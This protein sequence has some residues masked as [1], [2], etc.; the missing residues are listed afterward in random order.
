M[1]AF[2]LTVDK[3]LDHAAKWSGEREIVTAQSGQAARRTCYAHLRARSNRM[4]GALAA[5]QLGLGDRVATL[6]WNTQHHLEMYYALMGSGIVCHTL[7]P[8]LTVAHLAVMINEA[9]DRALAVAS[10]LAP[11]LAELAPLCPRI[12]HVF[13]MDGEGPYDEVLRAHRA[14]VWEQEA[15]LETLGCASAWGGFDEETPAGLCYT[16]GTT[17]AP[18][19]VLYTHRSNYLHT[20]RALQADAIALSGSDVV[21]VAVP[22]FHANAWGLPFAAPAVGA[23]LVLPGRRTDGASL[24]AIMRDEAVSVAVGI[25]TLWLGVLDHLDAVDGELP[26][27]KRVL[28]GGANCPDALIRRMES[29]LGARVQTS[30]GMTELSPVGTIA[31]RDAPATETR[32]SGRPVMGLDLKL[33]DAHGVVLPRQRGVVGHLKV[34]GAS[35]I[36]RYFKAEASAL[37]AE[38]YFDTGDLASID[39]AGNVSI[40]GRSK[41]LIKSGGEWIN[42]TEIEDIVGTH[43][44]VALAAVIARLDEKWGERPVLI[45]ECRQGHSLDARELL[46]FLR[47]KVAGWWLPDQILEVAAMPLASTGKIDKNQLRADYANGKLRAE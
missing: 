39:D 6:G 1:Q 37:D 34:K 3:F 25:Q 7:N 8:R 23:K 18:K 10:S 45:V 22:M 32:A 2:A 20:L 41:D 12:E 9:E 5:L 28:I 17:G 16:S 31:S 35:V 47:G 46:E 38:G 24:A 44:A 29:R 15:L 30:W 27:L 19:G 13:L 4:S 26:A 42:P 14:Q 36:E 21:L 43:S 40:C 33:T 11:L